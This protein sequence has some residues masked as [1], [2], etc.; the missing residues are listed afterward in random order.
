MRLSFILTALLLIFFSCKKE[1]NDFIW[2]K[3]FGSG[4]AYFIEATADSGLLSCGKVNDNPFI[5]KLDKNKRNLMEYR[6]EREGLF[7]SAWADTSYYI[8]AGSS[9][10]NMFLCGLDKNGNLLWDSLIIASFETDI[11]LLSYSGDGEFVAVG[12]QCPDSTQTNNT[13]ILFVKFDTSGNIKETREVVQTGL[14]SVNKMSVS[15]SGDIFMPVTR[16]YTGN[17][18]QAGCIKY[19]PDLNKIWETELFNNPDFGAES[20][21]ILAGD[22]GYIYVCG[23]TE[24][25]V[26]DGSLM[27]SFIVSLTTGGEIY[28]KKY[29]EK[30]NTG[31][32][33]MFDNNG[34]LLML[35]SNCFIISVI[36]PEDGSETD[37]LRMFDV[38]DPSSTD[39]FGSDFDLNFDGSLIIAGSYGGNYYIAQ[40]SLIQ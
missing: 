27:N 22:D 11:T 8:T 37:R 18:S 19:S 14:I 16:K 30:S 38:C 12:T 6:S 32:S 7:S 21:G 5:I 28:W 23:N 1:S 25:S 2:E 31:N 4:H 3:S 13:G 26:E 35:N 24:L 40:K 20:L 36:S 9:G 39:A 29:F 15:A 10:G 17:S 34:L 33:L